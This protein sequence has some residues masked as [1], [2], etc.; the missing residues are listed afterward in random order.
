M[1][2]RKKA[3]V[4]RAQRTGSPRREAGE[5]RDLGR[6]FCAASRPLEGTEAFKLKGDGTRF[7]F[8]KDTSDYGKENGLQGARMDLGTPFSS[9]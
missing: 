2:N 7:V 9:Y 5:R 6:F 1:K 4:P 8:L 3:Q